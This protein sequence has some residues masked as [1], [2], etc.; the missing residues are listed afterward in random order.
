MF[1]SL[2]SSVEA[3]GDRKNDHDIGGSRNCGESGVFRV[4]SDPSPPARQV[5]K[6]YPSALNKARTSYRE[7]NL[8]L[9]LCCKCPRKRAPKDDKYCPLH[10]KKLKEAR[11]LGGKL[12]RMGIPA[13]IPEE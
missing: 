13:I 10:R 7:T 12:R 4:D 9:G 11:R 5:P 6:R 3:G 2:L 1:Q 8:A